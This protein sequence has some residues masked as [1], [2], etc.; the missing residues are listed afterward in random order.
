MTVN[1]DYLAVRLTA[2]RVFMAINRKLS[3]V[4]LWYTYGAV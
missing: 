2:S 4:Q 3:V 1:A